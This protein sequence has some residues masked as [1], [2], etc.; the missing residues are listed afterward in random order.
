MTST[1]CAGLGLTSSITVAMLAR[2]R[3]L[4]AL[5]LTTA[6]SGRR[7][8]L[9][10]VRFAQALAG[11]VALALDNAGLFSDLESVE[12]RMD[13]VMSILDEAV[14]I[15]DAQGELVYANPAAAT[16]MGFDEVG[17]GTDSPTA[18]STA[19]IRER[20]D[21][22]SEDGTPISP[23]ALVGH[24]ALA[25]KPTGPLVLTRDAE[26]G[27]AQERWM[28]ARAKPILGP[29]GRALYSVTAIEDV[30]A[31]KRAEF[32][33]ALLA[34]AGE[35]LATSTDH[36][37]MLR[38][39]ADQLVPA[40]A[41]WCLI[42]VPSS[43]GTIE[44]VAIAH[45]DAEGGI[46]LADRRRRSSH[47][48]ADESGLAHVLRTGEARLAGDIMAPMSSGGRRLASFTL[49]TTRAAPSTRR[50]SSSPRRS[51]AA[52]PRRSRTRG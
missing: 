20:F 17:P 1:G 18:S 26:A 45:G 24:R 44:P 28:I 39:L 47:H 12:R 15:H 14:V 23:D 9:E 37:A 16:M 29:E 27:V 6:W 49:A 32:G 52:R 25:G 36:R 33:A 21:I 46:K 51:P 48:M 4:G 30:T 22:R 2:D 42:E 31:V 3:M 38:A 8:D 34:S 11:R 35:V 19:A 43:D 7:Y 5:T 10:D 50:T 40:F 41:D 13:N